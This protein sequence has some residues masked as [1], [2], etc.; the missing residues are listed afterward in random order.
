MLYPELELRGEINKDAMSLYSL[1][2]LKF[3][4]ADEVALGVG[5]QNI[6]WSEKIVINYYRDNNK[7]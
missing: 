2:G 3:R 1:L 5:I 4:I 6:K 7:F